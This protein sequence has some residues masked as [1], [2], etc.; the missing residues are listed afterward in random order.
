MRALLLV[1][2]RDRRC[3]DLV[4]FRDLVRT[5]EDALRKER[6]EEALRDVL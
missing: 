5:V 6:D 1:P 4:L 2:V 3:F